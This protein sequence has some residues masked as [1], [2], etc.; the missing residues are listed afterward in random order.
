MPAI[1]VRPVRPVRGHGPLLQGHHGE[2]GPA[3][4]AA[5]RRS[6]PCPRSMPSWLYSEKAIRAVA[7]LLRLNSQSKAPD[8]NNAGRL[9][10]ISGHRRVSR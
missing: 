2:W 5:Y 7:R 3:K 10:P 8:R 6:G 9:A 1:N 4:D